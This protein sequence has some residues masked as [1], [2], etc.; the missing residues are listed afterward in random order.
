MGIVESIRHS[1]KNGNAITR[2]IFINAIIFVLLHIILIIT[3]LFNLD[4]SFVLQYLAV[5]ADL[6]Q[7]ILKP[8]TAITYMFLH[9]DFFHILFNMLT[10]YWFG[11]IFLFS[12]T[13]KQLTGL[14]LVGGL[15]SA[16]VYILSLNVFPYFADSLPFSILMGASGSIMAIIVASA[17]KSPDL[18]VRLLLL[19]A[20][21]M[22]YIAI[23]TVLISFFGITGKNA[24]GE[25]AHLG[26]ALSGYIF[27]VSLRSG[28]DITGWINFVLDKITD[29]FKPGRLKTT[30]T[31]HSGSRKMS[32]AEFNM[33]KARNMADI[34]KILDKIKKSGYESLSADEKRK[35]FEQKK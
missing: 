9:Q 22:K 18:E 13:E 20:V 8:W 1:F 24:G 6:M 3:K 27:V 30:K 23:A 35:L 15:I 14:Y 26:G 4:A 34:D 10:L 16:L 31:K 25:L 12:F 7:L 21:K 5:P 32:D 2:L 29:L 17:M 11:K 33:S 28:N 19:G